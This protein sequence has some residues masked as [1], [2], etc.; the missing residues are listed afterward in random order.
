ME[1]ALQVIAGVVAAVVLLSLFLIKTFSWLVKKG[2]ITFSAPPT[3]SCIHLEQEPHVRW[4]DEFERDKAQRK[5]TTYGLKDLGYFTIYE[6]KGVILNVFIDQEKGFLGILHE[7]PAVG[8]W[9]EFVVQFQ[10]GGSF[11]VSSAKANPKIDQRPEHVKIH[12]PSA[13]IEALYEKFQTEMPPRAVLQIAPSPEA[14]I[15]FFEDGYKA[16]FDWRTAEAG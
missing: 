14:F 5:L 11:T 6:L 16:D 8:Q 7:D 3:P 1:I 9:A 2:V 4:Q 12:D 13:H 10:D 15:R